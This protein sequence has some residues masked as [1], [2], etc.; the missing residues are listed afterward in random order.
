MEF[1]ERFWPGLLGALLAG[2]FGY[3]LL[4]G[5]PQAPQRPL[6]PQPTVERRPSILEDEDAGWEESPEERAARLEPPDEPSLEFRL[7]EKPIAI[8]RPD[9]VLRTFTEESPEVK[10]ALSQ[11][12]IEIL[13]APESSAARAA[14]AYFEH[15]GLD[16]AARDGGDAMVQ[17]RAR[18]LSGTRAVGQ[19][20]PTVVVVDGQPLAN[21]SDA[22][23]QKALQAAVR[24]RV[25]ETLGQEV[26]S[27]DT[28][29]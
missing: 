16:Y 20:V 25:E 6:N 28:R 21:P 12:D 10:E 1:L 17:E 11:V 9:P 8:K 2:F 23:L 3:K 22:K 24:R 14:A 27:Q 18:R 13:A 15:N 26:G 5:S 7:I 4:S 19:E 29:E